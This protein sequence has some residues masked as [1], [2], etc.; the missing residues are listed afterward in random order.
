[1][2]RGDVLLDRDRLWEALN[3]SE[4]DKPTHLLPLVA[5]AHDAVLARLGNTAGVN[6]VV[7]VSTA[8]TK[9]QRRWERS[10]APWPT[11]LTVL[12]VPPAECLSR[13]REQGRDGEQ[14]WPALVEQWWEAYQPPG[15]DEGWVEVEVLR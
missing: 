12:E 6:R 2:R 10:R 7:R 9:A 3:L 14:D 15:S 13:I 1:M 8:A 11:A 4:Y 5:A